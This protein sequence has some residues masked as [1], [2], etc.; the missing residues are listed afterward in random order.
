MLKTVKKLCLSFLVFALSAG[1]VFSQAEPRKGKKP[2]RGPVRS[3][4]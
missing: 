1:F 2:H 3:S 4:L